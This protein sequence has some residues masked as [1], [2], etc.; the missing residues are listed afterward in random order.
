MNKFEFI[1]EKLI[2][3]SDTREKTNGNIKQYFESKHITINETA[4]KS[5][6]YSFIYDEIDYS[7]QF[8]IERKNSLSELAGNFTHKRER[9]ANEF[10]RIF[11]AG[12]KIVLVE[13]SGNGIADIKAGKYNVNF[14][15]KAFIGSL[16]SFS[17]RYGIKFEFCPKNLFPE[18]MFQLIFYYIRDN[19]KTN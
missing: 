19:Y 12:E 14:N 6:D 13:H 7:N 8:I 11:P 2:L 10:N 5:G 17:Y 16:L 1:P 3:L 9:F 18:Y 4:L 15:P